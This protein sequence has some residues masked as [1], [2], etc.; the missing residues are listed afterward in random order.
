MK[1]KMAFSPTYYKYAV[2]FGYNHA[3]KMCISW[4]GKYF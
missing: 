3:P 1:K 4:K 2:Y